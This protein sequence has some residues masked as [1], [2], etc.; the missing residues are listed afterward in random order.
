[1]AG[2][3]RPGVVLKKCK[4][5][6]KQRKILQLRTHVIFL[7][8][9]FLRFTLYWVFSIVVEAQFVPILTF[10]PMKDVATRTPSVSPAF[11]TKWFPQTL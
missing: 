3:A 4:A 11:S 7:H 8:D 9:R 10:V 6:N 2:S 1:L 5:G